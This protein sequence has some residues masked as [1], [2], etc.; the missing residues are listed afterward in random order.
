MATYYVEDK[1]KAQAEFI[2]KMQKQK[3]IWL[4][5]NLVKTKH[6][7]WDLYEMIHPTL[8]AGDALVY[9]D[10]KTNLWYTASVYS[11]KKINTSLKSSTLEDLINRKIW[12][13]DQLTNTAEFKETS[14]FKFNAEAA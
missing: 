10:V 12:F 3:T 5:G 7:H 9:N 4:E 11:S 6:K 13:I 8:G 1:A 14:N 2:A